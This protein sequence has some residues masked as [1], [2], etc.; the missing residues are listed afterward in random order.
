M[1]RFTIGS[2]LSGLAL[3]TVGILLLERFRMAPVV[4]HT[5]TA[6]GA[7]PEPL[8]V[9]PVTGR[10]QT[11]GAQANDYN[12]EDTEGWDGGLDTATW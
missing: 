11:G 9:D 1:P 5:G 4:A 7:G 10:V 6:P 8:A 3:A 2:L 12:L